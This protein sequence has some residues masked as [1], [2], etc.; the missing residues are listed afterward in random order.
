VLRF[1]ARS[2]PV[3]EKAPREDSGAE[4][5]ALR[6]PTSAPAP[7]MTLCC[8]GSKLTRE[9]LVRMTTLPVTAIHKPIPHI[10][11]LPRQSILVFEV[12]RVRS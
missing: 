12:K 3:R 6:M 8:Y 9:E 5:P 2:C 1:S 10:G 4:Q 11:G 7:T